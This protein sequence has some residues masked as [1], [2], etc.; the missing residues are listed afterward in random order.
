MPVFDEIK[1]P[2][3]YNEDICADKGDRSC[4]LVGED[5]ILNILSPGDSVSIYK[6]GVFLSTVA[7]KN[8]D[9]LLS[10]LEYGFYQ[11]R[12]IKGNQ[13]SDFTSWIMV[14]CSIESSKDES[15]VYFRSSNSLPFSFSFCNE[16]GGRK[17]PHSEV[18][19]RRFTED[20][21]SLGCICIPQDKIKSDRQFFMI[22][23]ETVFGK[24]ST[25][26]IKWL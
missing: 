19:C 9:L 17:Y 16:T 3:E 22:T 26:P 4:Y 7:L 12:L 10:G 1:E 6:D 11:A 5:V 14:D 20:E 21:V 18:L 2:F 13:F 15:I 8:E 24:V 25:T 23:F